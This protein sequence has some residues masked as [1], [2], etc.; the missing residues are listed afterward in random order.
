MRSLTEVWGQVG[1]GICLLLALVYGLQ[2]VQLCLL[3]VPSSFSTFS[4]LNRRLNGDSSSGG[5]SLFSLLFFAACA[6]GAMLAALIPLVVCLAPGLYPHFL[7]FAPGSASSRLLG[8]LL[9]VWGSAMS[10]AAVLTQ[11]RRARFD[12]GGE[13]EILITTGIFRL[14]R[15]SILAGLGLIYLGFLLLL[16]SVILA[17]GF[18]LFL[19]N[20]GFRMDLEEAELSRRF[21]KDYQAYAA[22]VGR[23][24]PRFFRQ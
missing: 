9:L 24:G 13:T 20:A 6:I 7:P 2:A 21:G 14:S 19:V 10:L 22:R 12:A 11:R 4:L 3:A 5:L 17:V 15:H 8:C 18:L 1:E 23:L 16:P